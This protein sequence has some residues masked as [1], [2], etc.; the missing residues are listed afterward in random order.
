M[1]KK[2]KRKRYKLRVTVRR[3]KEIF[4]INYNYYKKINYKYD[5]NNGTVIAKLIDSD[6]KKSIIEYTN[7]LSVEKEEM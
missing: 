7:V 2:F 3:E 5:K 1:F 4:A 6:G